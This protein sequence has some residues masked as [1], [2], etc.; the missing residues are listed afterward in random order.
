MNNTI[1]RLAGVLLATL[2]VASSAFAQTAD[3]RRKVSTD[4][5]QV[6]YGGGISGL[7][8][9]RDTSSGRMAKVLVVAKP[10]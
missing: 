4:L 6:V 10:F 2:L 1:R 7:S 3:T 9:A 5:Q 8:W